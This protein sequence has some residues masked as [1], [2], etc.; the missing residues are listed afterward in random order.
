MKI[1]RPLL[2]ILLIIGLGVG[3]YYGYTYYQATYQNQADVYQTVALVKGNLNAVV[4]ATGTVRSNQTT[5]IIWQT[6][7]SVLKVDFATGDQVKQGDS[8]ATLDR[9]TLAQSMILV[10]AD[11]ITAQRG[12]DNLRA[13]SL[14]KAQAFST[15]VSAKRA[16]DDA[17]RH[18]N[19][20]NYDRGTE[21]QVGA[22]RAEYLLANN[23]VDFFQSVYDHTSGDPEK[24]AKKAVALTNLQAAKTRRDKVLANLN[25][26]QGTPSQQDLNEAD[27]ALSLAKA[28]C[29]DAQR[30]W[31]RLKNG[32][33]PQD[34]ASAE[35]RILALQSTLDQ[36]SLR[37][38][39]SGTITDVKIKAGD[40]VSPGAVAFR[41][42]DLSPML[43]DVPIS[44]VDI[45]RV[46]PGQSVTMTFDA[47]SGKTYNGKVTQI[48]RIGVVSQGNVTFAVTIELLDADNNVSPGMTAA[49]NILVDQRQGVLLVPNRAV[50][51]SNGQRV[52][53]VVRNK[54][55]EAVVIELGASSDTNSEILTG[56][57]K[58][59]DLVILNPPLTV[60]GGSFQMGR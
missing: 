46:K 26:Y 31:D 44:E 21:S 3:G 54:Q 10:E 2:I 43:A 20:Y 57:L 6:S 39:F 25:W 58:E 52:V 12:L 1:I 5:T 11:L 38:P 37:A 55:A 32:P 48:G 19:I 27:S 16:L 53:Y 13:S 51:T 59:N 40:Q 36:R 28:K 41:L 49:V 17:Q 34:V 8:L 7:G 15:L 9:T 14:A 50:H 42:D 35:A 23:E 56:D 45:N 30:E 47:V 4:G 22:A 24:D 18:R 60:N 29:D 33:D